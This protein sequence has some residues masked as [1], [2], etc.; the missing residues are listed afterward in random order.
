MASSAIGAGASILGGFLGGK[1]ASKAAKIQARAYQQGLVQQ[2]QQ[3]DTTRADFMP[4]REAGSD[5]LSAQGGL[6]GLNGPDVQAAAIAALKG[7]PG[8][9]SLYD[10]GVDTVLQN[11]SATGGLRGGNVNNSLAQFGS[12]LLAQII[13]QQLGNLGG[14]SSLGAGAV[15]QGAQLGQQNTNAQSEL[16]IGKGNANAARAAAP[17]TAAVSTLQGLASQFGGGFGGAKGSPNLP[18]AGGF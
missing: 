2:Q 5:A 16:L 10:T 18:G 4:Y 6:L 14:I 11:A 1:G 7:S 8:F 15:G 13:Q 3:Y 12:S 17:Y 9:T